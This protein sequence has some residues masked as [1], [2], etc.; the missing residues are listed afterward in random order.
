[1]RDRLHTGVVVSVLLLVG[2]LLGSV[3]LEWGDRRG[4]SEFTA[5]RAPLAPGASVR[6]GA[7][8]SLE[9]LNGAGDP[10]AAERVSE[11]LRDMGF[12]VKTFGNASSFEQGRTELLDRSGRADAA[13]AIA[14]SL[15]GVPLRAEPAPEL[16]LDATLIL[17]DDWREVLD[18]MSR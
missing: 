6:E 16:Y 1:M 3:L 9:V 5:D 14:D 10:G 18:R 17:G 4:G 11:R 12:D 8:A 15:G 2:A 13:Q 7:R